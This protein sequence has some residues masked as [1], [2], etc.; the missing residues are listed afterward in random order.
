M[1]EKMVKGYN[2]Y[3]KKK[4]YDVSQLRDKNLEASKGEALDELIEMYPN[5][6]S[7]FCI[8]KTECLNF[9]DEPTTKVNVFRISASRNDNE[10]ILFLSI[11]M[12]FDPNVEEEE[13]IL[14]IPTILTR[15]NRFTT[16]EE[17]I[18]AEEDIGDVLTVPRGGLPS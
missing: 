11:Q 17:G 16:R 9:G 8:R 13:E 12:K 4:H 14:L 7:F 18:D 15:K 10:G 6:Q 1:E 5:H 2:S 3:S